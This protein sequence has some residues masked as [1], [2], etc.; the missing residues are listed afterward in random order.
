MFSNVFKSFVDNKYFLLEIALPFSNK[1]YYILQG[2][3]HFPLLP[4]RFP[5]IDECKQL[6]E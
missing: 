4:E 5:I 1:E 2:W 3:A 6:P